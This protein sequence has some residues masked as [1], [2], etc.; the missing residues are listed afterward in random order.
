M[1]IRFRIDHALGFCR[2]CNAISL[3]NGTF[4]RNGIRA[5]CGGTRRDREKLLEAFNVLSSQERAEILVAAFQ[6]AYAMTPLL[7]AEVAV[8]AAVTAPSADWN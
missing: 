4:S 1:G 3:I 8:E 5:S 6:C 7:D 2:L